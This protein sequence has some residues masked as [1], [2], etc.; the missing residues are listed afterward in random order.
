MA[1]LKRGRVVPQAGD[2]SAL[3]YSET[4][5]GPRR[6]PREIVD[7]HDAARAILA[8]AEEAAK[9]LVAQARAAASSVVA[10]ATEEARQA[11]AAKLAGLFLAL[12]QREEARA[13][14]DLER[15]IKL[16]VML[17][18]RLVGAALEVHPDRIVEMARR[19][20]EEARGARKV[21]IAA[22]P[23]D[24]DA[25]RRK[26]GELGFSLGLLEIALDPTLSRGSL[27]LHTDLG[28]LD[29]RLNPQLDRLAAALR[30]ALRTP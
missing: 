10:L 4:L 3:P 16:A 17:S 30:D 28:T 25:L 2:A 19:A 8:R 26:V 12:R 29:A 6:V 21:T 24:A 18:E 9:E 5:A 23:L 13:E 1:I 15:A 7:A 20:L 11:E 27:S 14:A 22:H